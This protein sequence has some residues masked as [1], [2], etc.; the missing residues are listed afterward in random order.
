MFTARLI[1]PGLIILPVF[2][3]LLLIFSPCN[4]NATIT[5]GNN[6]YLLQ[7]PNSEGG[8]DIV[9]AG[10]RFC[11]IFPHD[12]DATNYMDYYNFGLNGSVT[13]KIT[14]SSS[15][16][17]IEPTIAWNGAGH[18]IAYSTIGDI[19]FMIIDINGNVLL[20]PIKMPGI[21]LGVKARTAAPKVI[22]TG[23]GYAV[24]GLVL[25]PSDP[26]KPDG[27]G[28]HYCNLFYWF[29]DPYGNVVNQKMVGELYGL[30][31]PKF[32]GQEMYWYDVVW[33]G[34]SFFVAYYHEVP[35]TPPLPSVCYRLIDINGN[36]LTADGVAYSNVISAKPLLAWSGTTFALSAAG[37][38]SSSSTGLYV[39]F[40][41]AAGTPLALEN[42]IYEAQIGVYTPPVVSWQGDKFV[43]GFS[44]VPNNGYSTYATLALTTYSYQGN[45]LDAPYIFGTTEPEQFISAGTYMKIVGVG[46]N[47]LFTG[48]RNEIAY[49]KVYP[50]IYNGIGDIVTP[51]PPIPIAPFIKKSFQDNSTVPFQW[52]PVAK[53]NNYQLQIADNDQ[54]N[55]PLITKSFGT[56]TYGSVD[57]SSL[58]KAQGI[59]PGTVIYWRIKGSST[60]YSQAYSFIVDPNVWVD[61]V[62]FSIE[63]TPNRKNI[64]SIKN[65]MQN[66]LCKKFHPSADSQIDITDMNRQGTPRFIKG[67][68]PIND[69]SDIKTSVLIFLSDIKDILKI[70]N[71]SEELKLKKELNDS[72][73]QTHLR[74]EQIYS[75]IPIWSSSLNVHIN[76]NGDIYAIN[77]NFYPTPEE[78]ISA[79]VSKERAI[80]VALSLAK[81]INPEISL[82]LVWYPAEDG[83]RLSYKIDIIQSTDFDSTYFVDANTE[84]VYTYYSNIQNSYPGTFETGSGT[85]SVGVAASIPLYKYNNLYQPVITTP[86]YDNADPLIFNIVNA[87]GGIINEGVK[88]FNKHGCLILLNSSKWVPGNNYSAE[89]FNFASMNIADPVVADSS[90]YFKKTIDFYNTRWG[91]K[92]WDN[93]GSGIPVFCHLPDSNTGGGYDNAYFSPRGYFAFGDGAD[94][95]KTR[96]F[97][98][99]D[100]I[101]AHEFS[102]GVTASTS[103]L[104]YQYMSGAMNES[105][106]DIMPQGLDKDDFLIG[107]D[108]VISTDQD[109][110]HQWVRNFQ[111]PTWG[112]AWDPNNMSKGGQPAHMNSYYVCG[113][114]T[115]NGGVHINSGIINKAAYE[116]ATRTSR[117]VMIDIFFRA[118]STYLNPDSQFIDVRRACLQSASDLYPSE[119]AKIAAVEQSFDA[120]GI[121]E[122]G[123]I[124]GPTISSPNNKT[125]ITGE[126]TFAW[127]AVAGAKY[128]ILEFSTDIDFTPNMGLIPITVYQ[129]GTPPNSYKISDFGIQGMKWYWRV[130]SD[131]SAFSETREFVYGPAFKEGVAH[132]FAIYSQGASPV[133][134]KSITKQGDSSWLSFVSPPLPYS[135]SSPGAIYVQMLVNSAG[136]AK[137]TYSEKLNIGSSMTTRNPYPNGVTVNLNIGSNISTLFITH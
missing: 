11:G 46:D 25:I 39:R 44:I 103:D 81:T 19:R 15:E 8:Q 88:D 52:L 100:D 23:N 21:P 126:T 110:I 59:A 55:N 70:K 40:F 99:A 80:A 31:Y 119:P 83:L 20:N 112:G 135:L 64:P 102:H 34:Y 32:R 18:G 66:E 16:A 76:K 38:P 104:I 24:F 93:Q 109:F 51:L 3:L 117:D 35:T 127:S 87:Q 77:G 9:F 4:S 49:N 54:F 129:S 123:N 61:P 116:L 22:W 74:Y 113:P 134:I 121:S 111:D 78:K 41:D 114:S 131:Q 6:L 115:D 122:P 29:I 132:V 120:V 72:L 137:G 26:T 92:S 56:T 58:N 65:D 98:S 36:Q 106:S 136:L 95:T 37:Y 28:I 101:V 45:L 90:V 17:F 14:F 42:K 7:G 94:A 2:L 63:Q 53:N 124:P 82:K 50:M 57:L 75:N 79:S 105:F 107:E 62:V 71:P 118:N 89:L 84:R 96:P 1:K 130:R 33:S 13:S 91:W 133:T 27:T 125:A 67:K 10:D 48:L 86:W 73:T 69:K 108:L 5:F 97:S 85:T 12:L 43:L 60:S 30:E 47:L 68:F 128:Y